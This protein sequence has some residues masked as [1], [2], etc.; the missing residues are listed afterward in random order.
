MRFTYKAQMNLIQGVNFT[1]PLEVHQQPI[2]SV[3]VD[4]W[5]P[6]LDRY[7][8]AVTPVYNYNIMKDKKDTRFFDA[9][10]GMRINPFDNYFP[11]STADTATV[12]LSPISVSDA[13]KRDVADLKLFP[14]GYIPPLVRDYICSYPEEAVVRYRLPFGV[15]LYEVG[16]EDVKMDITIDNNGIVRSVD[17]MD[18]RKRHYLRI[19]LLSDISKCDTTHSTELLT[20]P[21]RTLELFQIYDPEITM[22]DSTDNDLVVIGDKQITTNST[23]NTIKKLPQTN[24]S[25]RKTRLIG[26][27]TVGS[28]GLTTR[29]G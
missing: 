12:L 27:P 15:D 4:N 16:R 17:E 2:P 6:Y 25:Y 22:G 5:M 28:F 20:N 14:D 13:D 9:D 10:G 23:I 1:F 29:R 3:F 8:A 19:Y 21:E 11:P 26:R 18:P 24:E 7:E